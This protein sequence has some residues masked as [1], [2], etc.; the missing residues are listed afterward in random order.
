[1][2][3]DATRLFAALDATWPPA[4]FV[5][6]GPWTLREGKGGGQ[7]VSAATAN[8]PVSETDIDRAEAGMTALGQT[9]LFMIRDRDADLDAWLNARGYV[10]VDPVVIYAAPVSALAD[11]QP[12]TAIVPTWPMLAIQRDLWQ[13]AGIGPG[14]FAVMERAATPRTALL[15]RHRDTPAGVAFLAADGEIAMIHA[16]EVVPSERRSGVAGRAMRAAAHWAAANGAD[17]LALAVTRANE[18]A[19]ALYRHLGMTPAA[20]YHYRRAPEIQA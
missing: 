4:R 5:T 12:M 18:G 1:M 15:A 10:V 13:S 20:T 8:S 16:L 14:R 2:I 11:P 7:R 6:E 3:P 17:W 9:P 19:N